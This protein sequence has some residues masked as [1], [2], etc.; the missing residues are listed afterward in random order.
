M[1]ALSIP[2]VLLSLAIP[3]A[4]LYMRDSR[5]E[6]HDPEIGLKSAMYFMFS[7][8]II[9]ILVGLTVIV[10]DFLMD[11]KGPAGAKSAG[12]FNEMQRLGAAMMVSGF[13][14]GLFHL[15]VILGFTNDR[16]FPAAR[17]VFLGWR[18]AIHSLVVLGAFTILVVQVFQK[19]VN[20]DKLKPVFGVLLVWTPS[21]LAHLIL[22]RYYRSAPIPR[23]RRSPLED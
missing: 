1:A 13:A 14:V 10:I 19:D 3:Y 16:R 17:R 20:W 6:E 15:V 5:N 12:D 18:L 11:E 21:W 8:S 22:I 9:L 2:L 23:L 4:V 7:L